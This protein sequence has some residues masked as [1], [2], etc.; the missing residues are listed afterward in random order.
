[1]KTEKLSPQARH[2]LNEL[3]AG[4]DRLFYFCTQPAG[5]VQLERL[6]LAKRHPTDPTKAVIIR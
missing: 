1:M 5:W 2:L 6:G 4:N 3:A